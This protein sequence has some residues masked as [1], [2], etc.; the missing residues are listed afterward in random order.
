MD[1]QLLKT[2]LA[3]PLLNFD[4]NEELFSFVSDDNS[5]MVTV[6]KPS[7][8]PVEEFIPLIKQ[9]WGSGQI[10]NNG[11]FHKK[12]ENIVSEY[13]NN[14]N[15]SL[16]AN[17]T[18]AL[19]LA[20]KALDIKGEVITTPYS[21]VATSHV[22]SWN[23]L[24]PV[25]CDIDPSTLNICSD[26]IEALI[27]K[28]TTAIL[29]TH[30]YGRPCD[31]EKI[32]LIAKKYNL[33]VIYDAAHAFGVKIN[34]KSLLN[35]GDVSA[36]S[37]HGTKVFTTFEGGAVV[38]NNKDIKLKIDMYKNFAFKN[39]NTV[40]DV[41]I[42]AKMNE[43]QAALGLL[44]FKYFDKYINRRKKLYN[45]YLSKLK[46]ISGID[47]KLIPRNIVYNYS[48]LPIFINE[49]KFGKSRDDLYNHLKFHNILA[50]KYFYP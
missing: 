38:A 42:N 29:A 32:D 13:L 44:Q 25:F 6:S 10:T 14:K 49:K 30:V 45:Y 5:D 12:F 31:L 28:N 37:F 46:Y 18:L 43:F 19:L 36:V 11:D 3:K 39:E 21:F 47:L 7:L 50:R 33:K 35:Y 9:I 16:V 8:P 1:Y 23:G 41:G 22:L 26:K 27:T 20:L 40:V 4:L 15:V 34:N 17:G 48:Y 24:T 2:D